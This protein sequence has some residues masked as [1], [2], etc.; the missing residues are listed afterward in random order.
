MNSEELYEQWEYLAENTIQKMFT[1]PSNFA[2]SV[3][4]EYQDLIQFA[5]LG[6][7]KGCNTYT[8]EKQTSKFRS[9]A[10]RNIRWKVYE[11]VRKYGMNYLVRKNKGYVDENRVSIVSMNS[12][13]YKDADDDISYDDIISCDNINTFS[14]N[15]AVESQVI[16]DLETSAMYNILT[17]KEKEL[18]LMKMNEYLSY[19]E[20][21]Q[22]FGVT[23]QCIG[24]RFKKIQKKIN[25]HMG[26]ATA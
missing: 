2:K 13:P 25:R 17:D 18:V 11:L 9:F 23:K 12:K 19:E 6:L 7:W 22:R 4:L 3:N 21:G 8:T 15:D 14:K 10:I 5:R 26:V 1:N 20:I 24:M 16:S